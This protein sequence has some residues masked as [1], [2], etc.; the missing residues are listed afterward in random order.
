[1]SRAKYRAKQAGYT[2]PHFT[3]SEWLT[4]VE[5]C[6]GRCLRCGVVEDL[7]VDHIVP[8]SLSGSN[9]IENIQPLCSECNGIK[10]CETTDYR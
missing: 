3:G 7:T 4:L 9:T 2:G 1:V 5:A 10:G 6:G 8:L